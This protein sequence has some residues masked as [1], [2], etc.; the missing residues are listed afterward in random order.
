MRPWQLARLAAT[1]VVLRNVV[2][3]ARRSMTVTAAG[4][5]PSGIA[6]VIPARDEAARI[7]PLLELVVG[8]PGV[9]E[10]VVVDDESTDETSVVARAAGARVVAGR[11]LP[12]A[13]AG[14]AWAMQQ[15]LDAVSAGW[16]VALDADTRPSPALPRALVARAMADGLDLLTVGGRFEC[17]TPGLRWLHPAMLTTLVYR[18]PPPGAIDQGPVHRRLGNGQCMAIR[19][20]V[21]VAAG[22]FGP[23]GH[24]TVEDVALVRTMATAGFRVG[25]LDGSDLLT[26]RMYESP[27][28]A[29]HGWGRSLAMPGVDGRGRRLAGLAVLALTQAAPLVRVV[30]RRADALDALLLLVRVGTLAGTARAYSRRDVAY[31]L[32]PLADVV[33]VAALVRS[34]VASPRAWRGRPSAPRRLPEPEADERHEPA[35]RRRSVR[36]VD[37]DLG[38]GVGDEAGADADRRRSG[39]RARERP[40]GAGDHG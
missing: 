40:A 13:W 16:V 18:F 2:R 1:A 11:S 26:V 34:T 27:I 4:D 20:G 39:D 22:G 8:A 38:D 30:A 3:A 28:E 23:V 31:W 37:G 24:H 14:K 6:V 12:P 35:G 25:S 29:W 5:G 33:A 19:R 10:V 7:G 36:P 9:A 15:G 32:S 17:P 21:L